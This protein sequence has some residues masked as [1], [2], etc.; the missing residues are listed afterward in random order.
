MLDFNEVKIVADIKEATEKIQL[1]ESLFGITVDRHSMVSLQRLDVEWGEFVDVEI[2]EVKNRD[3]LKVKIVKNNLHTREHPTQLQTSTDVN[4]EMSTTG[5]STLL[6]G[7][8]GEKAVD[9]MIKN[10]EEHRSTL[11]YRFEVAQATLSS[12]RERPRQRE[13]LGRNIAFICSNCHYRGHRVNNCRQPPCQGFFECGMAALHKE[14]REQIKKVQI[15]D[16]SRENVP[17]G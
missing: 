7:H 16:L 15:C 1:V 6:N 9:R 13:P 17:N 10:L 11:Q 3:K 2:K 12:L 5:C 4:M 8:S 14:H